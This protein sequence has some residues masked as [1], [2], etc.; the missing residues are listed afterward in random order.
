MNNIKHILLQ[1][2][3]ILIYYLFISCNNAK[4]QNDKSYF[5]CDIYHY[6]QDTA[7]PKQLSRQDTMN[8]IKYAI[9][10]GNLRPALVHPPDTDITG[11]SYLLPAVQNKID[12]GWFSF[13][14]SENREKFSFKSL[15]WEDIYSA[16]ERDAVFYGKVIDKRQPN[17]TTV[18]L[19]YK[20]EYAIEVTDVIHSYFPLK[21]GDVVLVKDIMGYSC[22]SNHRFGSISH[23]TEYNI[24]DKS[25][26]YLDRSYDYQLRFL[27]MASNKLNFSRYDDEY[28]PQAFALARSNEENNERVKNKIEDL[29]LFFKTK[30]LKHEYY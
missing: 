23:I 6:F 18:C 25:V 9:R 30:F 29:K 10:Y 13:V 16:I 27:W 4:T 3:T 12:T 11:I 14:R 17:D 5:D 8:F 1:G 20:T 7:Y 19:W 28:C 24:G 21:N 2:L 15:T 26:F 22:G